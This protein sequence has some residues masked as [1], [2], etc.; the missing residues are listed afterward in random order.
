MLSME[1]YCRETVFK[2]G[3]PLLILNVLT[4][5]IGVDLVQLTKDRL[6]KHSILNVFDPQ[7]EEFI[8]S[9]L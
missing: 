4:L 5:F 7:D 8:A 6:L 9:K 3:I 2:F 1:E